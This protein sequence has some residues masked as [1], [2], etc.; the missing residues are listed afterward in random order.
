M[1]FLLGRCVKNQLYEVLL[2][3]QN[4]SNGE[5]NTKNTK[6]LRLNIINDNTE[7]EGVQIFN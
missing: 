2:A 6:R 3:I 4:A 5:N 7:A 1:W